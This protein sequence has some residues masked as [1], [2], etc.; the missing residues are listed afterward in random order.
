MCSSMRE[1]VRIGKPCR[2]ATAPDDNHTFF[3]GSVALARGHF[4]R[5]LE[6]FFLRSRRGSQRR[7]WGAVGREVEPDE[8]VFL[9]L[10]YYRWTRRG[11][12][13]GC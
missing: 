6:M 8:G 10:I 12:L 2:P 9:V 1:T 4:H 7:H 11:S 5:R 13:R 3:V